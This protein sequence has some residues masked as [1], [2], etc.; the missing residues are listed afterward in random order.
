MATGT[1]R[2][3]KVNTN[4]RKSASRS[5]KRN[6]KIDPVT[7]EVIRGALETIAFEMAT[8][9]S[10]TATTPILNQ[11]N[12]RNATIMDWQGRLAAL[13][14]GVPQ[15][16]LSSMGPVQ[17]AL[18]FFGK[19]GFQDGDVVGC[20]DPYHGGGHLPDWSI[21]APVFYQGECVLFASIQCHHA[22][23]AG[24]MPGGYPADA[25]DIWAEGF[26]CPAVKLVEGG[27]E[28]KDVV[29]LLQTNNRVPTYA[30]DLKSQIGAAQL[31]ARLCRELI[32]KYGVATVKAA[33]DYMIELS[34]RRFREE[35]AS[36]PDGVYEADSF[37]DHD[38]KGNKDVKVHC[39]ATVKGE[40]LTIDY[41]GSD[42]REWLQAWST[43]C[44]TRSMTMAQLC[45]M[46]DPSIPKN[47]GLFN[48]IEIIYPPNTVVD[49]PVGKPVSMGTHHPGCEV[50]E[51]VALALSKA[52]PE[53]TVP[54]VY[55]AA[56][57][58]VVFGVNPKNNQFFVDHSVDTT[59]TASAA[60][61]GADAW[62]CTNAGF[63][64]LIM[65]TAEINESIFP[66]RHRGNDLMTDTGGP[67]QW[68]G[69]CGSWYVKEAIA[70]QSVY[71][72][73]L[74]MKYPS[75]G[76]NGGHNGSPN[77]LW[78]KAGGPNA[79]HC[80]HTALY[81]PLEPG[82]RIEYKFAG[83]AGWGDPLERDPE[84]VRDDVLDEY[85]SRESAERDYGV[86]FTGN[87]DDYSLEVD[88]PKTYAR[89][90]EMCSGV[91]ADA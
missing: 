80:E 91:T 3:R 16:M 39:K 46:I 5:V 54:Q 34:D 24:M 63:G 41:T 61:Y 10:R 90:K 9:V 7:A 79:Y 15:F 6:E 47:Q 86:I 22:D 67:G 78:L 32:A 84:K 13:A 69:Q 12:E 35:I 20:N 75:I 60:C 28:R 65:A 25:M 70:P 56:M 8:H 17:F 88:I 51:S 29:Y 38:V 85:V 43:Q 68:R 87:V 21:F 52:I 44:N 76:I 57:P 23:T 58:T 89:R 30:G 50:S 49:P 26:R 2:K 73:V 4:S 81:V 31:G 42:D 36:W 72:Y 11:S 55:K 27:K 64:N 71:T 82:E 37:F 18:E 59:A 33:V 1:S 53:K 62:G 19:D 77:E 66:N 45:S 83:G 74:G 48:C 40:K 14:V